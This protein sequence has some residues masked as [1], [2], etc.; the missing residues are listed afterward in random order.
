[1]KTFT[2]FLIVF[3]LAF[4]GIAE[5][6][7]IFETDYDASKP[8]QQDF[9]TGFV[10]SQ[11]GKYVVTLTNPDASRDPYL[12]IT[13]YVGS[14]PTNN[15][16]ISARHLVP[17]YSESPYLPT[18]EGAYKRVFEFSASVSTDP[19][20]FDLTSDMHSGQ[21]YTGI[22]HVKM[23][24]IP[25][26]ISIA[27][28]DYL[29]TITSGPTQQNSAQTDFDVGPYNG[30][31]I[32]RN[33]QIGSGGGGF[34][35]ELDGHG[36]GIA[37]QNGSWTAEY[38]TFE[39]GPGAHHLELKHADDEWRDNVGTRQTMVYYQ[40]G[41]PPPPAP[42]LHAII[43]GVNW[44][45]PHRGDLGAQAVYDQL[46]S[47]T[48]WATDNPAPII[49]NPYSDDGQHNWLEVAGAVNN[50]ADHLNP[51]DSFVF[52]F[53][54]HGGNYDSGDETGVIAYSRWGIPG[55]STGDEFLALSESYYLTDDELTSL[56]DYQQWSGINKLFVLAACQSGGFWGDDLTADAGDLE[57][58]PLTALLAAAP[59]GENSLVNPLTG[60][61]FFG[62]AF[63]K[64]FAKNSNNGLLNADLN[65]NGVVT[66]A[67]LKE[68]MGRYDWS[69]YEGTDAYVGGP[70]DPV[71]A[72]FE[73]N[74]FSDQTE[75]FDDRLATT[76]P[77][78]ATI[79]LIVP[80]LLGLAGIAFRKMRK[81]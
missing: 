65:G 24:F 14:T 37:E 28:A 39:V 15:I 6:V 13:G 48:N 56:F 22:N 53:E 10:V 7:M 27:D 81:K 47:L 25:D 4:S 40:Q 62:T 8:L 77:E 60:R 9:M 26:P 3:L 49:L 29:L 36:L 54:G 58:L 61:S 41:T 71:L 5:A 45:Y 68:Y 78:P 66:F 16:R 11:P 73:W 46:S 31:L 43:V 67:E 33:T 63:E 57:R 70:F 20:N 55:Y 79:A 18:T 2:L 32:L 51:G 76:V 69:G 80:A 38:Y 19:L 59:E 50:I 1:M 34:A 23:E 72:P 21:D 12:W 75:G 17:G 44:G 52:Y 74:V 42:K 30:K 35:V 64:A